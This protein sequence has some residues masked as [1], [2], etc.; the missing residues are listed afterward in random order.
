MLVLVERQL[1]HKQGGF[2][3]RYSGQAWKSTCRQQECPPQSRHCEQL[4]HGGCQGH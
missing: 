3:L 2:T 1:L 4:G